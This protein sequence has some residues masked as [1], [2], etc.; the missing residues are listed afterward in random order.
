MEMTKGEIC[1]RFRRGGGTKQQ[2]KVLADLNAVPVSEIKAV[3]IE[4]GEIKEETKPEEPKEPSKEP[5]KEPKVMPETIVQVLL[6]RIE[7]LD[8]ELSVIEKEKKAKEAEYLE[9][10]AFMN[11]YNKAV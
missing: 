4:A 1:L 7:V 3:L 10:I 5:P 9:I 11:N 2:I 6:A 8:Q